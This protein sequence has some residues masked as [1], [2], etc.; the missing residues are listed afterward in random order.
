MHLYEKYKQFQLNG[1]ISIVLSIMV[2]FVILLCCE[3][4]SA[5]TTCYIWQSFLMAASMQP[6]L[7]KM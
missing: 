5:T 3:I 6:S 4:L 2:R 1:F 7:P